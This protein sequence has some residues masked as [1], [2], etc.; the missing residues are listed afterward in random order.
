LAYFRKYVLRSGFKICE[1]NT[2]KIKILALRDR[3]MA[4]ITK[5]PGQVPTDPNREPR[6]VKPGTDKFK[7]LMKIDKSGEREKKKKKRQ[8][9]SEE[10]SKAQ[11]RTG[12][13][14]PDKVSETKKAQEIRKIQKVGES[15]KRQSMA[16][17]RA[18][19]SAAAEEAAA[20]QVNQKKIESLNLEKIEPSSS[21]KIRARPAYEGQIE[22]KEI[23]EEK[24]EAVEKKEELG[25]TSLRREVKK[26]T[27]APGS[28]MVTPAATTLGPLFIAPAP[29]VAPAYTQ[30]SGEM[31]ALFEKM[32]SQIFIMQANGINETTI[33]LN[34]P[35]FASSMFAGAQIVIKEYSTAPLAFNIEFLGSPQN[36]IFFEQNIASLRAAFTSEERKYSIHRIES[37]LLSKQ[38]KPL[39]HRKEKTSDKGKEEK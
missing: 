24:I 26:E 20:A 29:E 35:E 4:D 28:P 17:K 23:V 37:R 30:L 3:F 13:A 21:E 5:I 12:S 36:S 39:F 22:Q 32:I 33:H 25:T 8:E 2:S 19:E 31:L 34:T 18:E 16:Q 27:G 10:D 1:K 14:T 9:E 6:E 11:L 38:E 7:D 15:E